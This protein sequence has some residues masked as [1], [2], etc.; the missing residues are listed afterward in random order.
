[1]TGAER[2]AAGA[3]PGFSRAARR[4]AAAIALGATLFSVASL[5]RYGVTID[6]PALLYAGDRTLHALAHPGQP[7]ALDFRAAEPPGFSS[8]FPR[9]PDPDDPEHY[10]VLP[11]LVAAATDA[12]LG[13]ALGLTPVDGHHAG[14]ALLSI[15]LLFLYT[16]YAC[17]LLG[18]AAGVAAAIALA[19]FPTAVGH[20]FN[21]PKDWPCAGFYALTVLAAGVGLV[22]KR[23]RQ[24][25]LAGLFLGLALSCKQNAVFAAV[26]VVL[27][28][29][30]VYRL[31][32]HGES[33]GRASDRRLTTAFLLFPYVGCAIFAVAWP[34]LWWA[35]PSVA[36]ARLGDFVGFARQFSSDARAGFSAHPFRCLAFMTP[37]LVLVAAAAGCWPGRTPTRERLAKGALLAIWLLL[38]LVR[39]ALPHANFY[40]ANRHFLEYVPALCALAGLGF[41]EGWRRAA[42]IVLA[43]F[44]RARADRAHA[45]PARARLAGAVALIAGAAALAWPVAQYH[46]FETAY[47]NFMVGGLGGAQRAGLFRTSPT[48]YVNGTEGDYWLSSLREGARAARM[49]APSGRP[50]GVCAWLP[51][52]AAI[53]GDGPPM[54]VT[55]EVERA[56]VP[57]IYAAPRGQRCSWKRL[58]ELERWRPV[59]ERI[60][61]G[62]GLIYEILGPRGDLPHAPASPPTVYDP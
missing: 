58:H 7:G 42:P 62:G 20:A 55:A 31:L 14:L 33:R 35:G 15:A 57:V 5:R 51:A 24:L 40:D 56:E 19:C 60:T 61:R 6:E 30:F 41:A 17:R 44:A 49:L 47:F 27:A 38:P 23:P 11:A 10:P 48:E 25:W 32:Y 37:P 34:W 22:E 54:E 16:L 26:T 36:V 46:P 43:Y 59:L 9:L 2:A 18:D 13:R 8:H 39:I 21:D 52:L 1:M 4:A 28:T 45:G 29:P 12:T 50:L 3:P 53:D